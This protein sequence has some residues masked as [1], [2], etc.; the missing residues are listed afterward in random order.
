MKYNVCVIGL[1]YVGLVTAVKLA[2]TNNNVFGIE[3]DPIKKCYLIKGK[4]HFLSLNWR[5]KMRTVLQNKK[6]KLFNS[7]NKQIKN[8]MFLWSVSELQLIKKEILIMNI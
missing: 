2:L 4:V 5:P 3:N 8:V 7:L 1:G 6:L